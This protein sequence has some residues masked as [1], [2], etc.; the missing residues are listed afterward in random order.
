[1]SSP[2]NLLSVLRVAGFFAGVLYGTVR[3]GKLEK[4]EDQLVEDWAAR[5]PARAQ[6]LQH[7]AAAAAAAAG[8]HHHG[9]THTV[10]H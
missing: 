6:E 10:G 7:A 1:M 9:T 3:L 4:L 5:N 8:V 2:S